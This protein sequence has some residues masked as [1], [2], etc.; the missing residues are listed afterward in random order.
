MRKMTV[1]A[2]GFL[3][4]TGMYGQQSASTGPKVKNQKIWEKE[5]EAVVVH[6]KT[7]E[8]VVTGP[9]AKNARIWKKDTTG[10]SQA[11]TTRKHKDLTGPRFKNRKPWKK[12]N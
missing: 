5:R 8:E 2:L 12:G 11:V 9:R 6:H 10:N 1:L 3:C 4:A 7:D